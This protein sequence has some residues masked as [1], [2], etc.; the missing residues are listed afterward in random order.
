MSEAGMGYL[1]FK[2]GACDLSSS[3]L[4]VISKT[5]CNVPDKLKRNDVLHFL[6]A[7][8]VV[9]HLTLERHLTKTIK[10]VQTTK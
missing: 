10:R 8:H 6:R 1:T 5:D 3:L 4:A 7:K 2:G 9:T